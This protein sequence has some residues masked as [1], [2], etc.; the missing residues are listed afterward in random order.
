MAEF[1]HQGPTGG[2]H[3]AGQ[4]KM[5]GPAGKHA[6]GASGGTPGS[7]G[8]HDAAAKVL[9]PPP[10]K[11]LVCACNRD[12]TLDE[13]VSI[14]PDATQDN[15]TTFLPLLNA[16]FKAYD[17]TTCLRKAHMLAQ[18]G[19]ESG[20][21]KWMKELGPDVHGGYPGR[22]LLQLTDEKNYKAYGK[23]VNHDFLGEHAKEVEEPKWAADSAGWFW[24]KY[25]ELNPAADRNDL[26]FICCRING[27]FNG[28]DDRHA[29][30]PIALDWLLVHTCKTAN[31]G[32]QV[33]VP[34]DKSQIYDWRVYAYAWGLWNDPTGKRKGIASPV[35][36]DRK[37][38]YQRF[39]DLQE[40]DDKKVLAKL[41]Q[42]AAAKAA[43]AARAAA[44]AH[45]GKAGAP[46]A[47]ASQAAPAAPAAAPPDPEIPDGDAIFYGLKRKAAIAKAKEGI[48]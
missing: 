15:C 9:P 42:D 37:A 33:Y 11:S 7:V 47:A 39:L 18:I 3:P 2:A 25:K 46:G 21:L 6:P 22:G 10:K 27:G 16:A 34:F 44:K 19:P 24:D 13:L 35:V 4:A 43:K 41:K 40:E 36:A 23:A 45:P 31:I 48:K 38:G 12:L 29:R 26:M 1:R 32:D 5:P 20:D 17:V 28:Y 8:K 30:L 14:L